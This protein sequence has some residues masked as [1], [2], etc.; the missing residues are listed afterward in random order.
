ML[1][2][3]MADKHLEDL[4]EEHLPRM[5]SQS[6]RKHHMMGETKPVKKPCQK[7]KVKSN[8]VD[9]ICNQTNILTRPA[10]YEEACFIFDMTENHFGVS[11]QCI[12]ELRNLVS[13]VI[14]PFDNNYDFYRLNYNHAFN[15]YPVAIVRAHTV[16][17][18]VAYD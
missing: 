9:C 3:G 8:E 18:V 11:S 16:D 17:D 15:I 2:I 12:L 4:D 14:Y 7:C 10:D 5:I 13:E 1:E 6:S